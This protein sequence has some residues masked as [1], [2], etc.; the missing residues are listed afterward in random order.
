MCFGT[1][2]R[3]LLLLEPDLEQL[4]IRLLFSVTVP[5]SIPKMKQLKKAV[6]RPKFEIQLPC[7]GNS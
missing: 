6:P 1:L 5:F 3:D 7:C 4:N 2:R